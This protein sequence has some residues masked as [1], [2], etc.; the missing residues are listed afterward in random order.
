MDNF[1]I[2]LKDYTICLIEMIPQS[3]YEGMASIFCIGL[4]SFVAW[5]GWKKGL[6]YSAALLLSNYVFLLLYSTVFNR[7]TADYRKFDFTP[8]WSYK[9]IEEGAKNLILENVINVVI[10]LPVGFLL[11]CSFV[12]MKWWKALLIGFG[13]S[14]VIETLQ[15]LYHRGFSEVDDVMHNTFGC[16]IGYGIYKSAQLL[17]EHFSNKAKKFQE[18]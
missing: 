17:F 18:A 5:K 8:F 13:I 6:C 14:A 7:A 12:C 15:F 10:F 2:Q 16:A 4:V 9:A 1:L 3:V 11:G